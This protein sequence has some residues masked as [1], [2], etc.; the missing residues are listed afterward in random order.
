MLPWK[1][2]ASCMF[3]DAR[4]ITMATQNGREGLVAADGEMQ[5]SPRNA[6]MQGLTKAQQ[7]GCSNEA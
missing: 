2:D 3:I 6:D 5:W 1:L 7:N 4:A